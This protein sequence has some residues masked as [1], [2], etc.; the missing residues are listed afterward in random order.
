MRNRMTIE[1]CRESRARAQHGGPHVAALVTITGD[2][3][4]MRAMW[5]GKIYL[6]KNGG[7]IGIAA[8]RPHGFAKSDSG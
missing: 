5:T 8:R 7:Q 4:M 3:R 1:E 6:R 2:L